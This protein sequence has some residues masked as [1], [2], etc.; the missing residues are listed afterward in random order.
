MAFKLHE[1]TERFR[2]AID[3]T[4]E[5]IWDWNVKSGEVKNDRYWR[6]FLGFED[7]EDL[8]FDS[9]KERVHPDS[10]TVFEN[11][12]REYLE[13]RRKY[14]EYEYRI[15]IKSGEWKW[16]WTRGICIEY[17]QDNRPVRFIGTHRDITESKLAEDTL[18]ELTRFQKGVLENDLVWINALWNKAAE[19]ISGYSSGEVL[20]HG[21]VWEWLYPDEKYRFDVYAQAKGFI[22]LGNR[23]EDGRERVILWNSQD[24]KDLN[25][26]VV[27]SV[28]LGVD[29]TKR[30][31]AEEEIKR[32]F[33]E[34]EV[35]IREI[36][37]RI[38]NN[39]TSVESLL[40]LQ[41]GSIENTEAKSIIY[42]AVN[43]V[44]SIR[45]IYDKLLLTDEYSKLSVTGYLKKLAQSVV[46]IFPENQ[47]VNVDLEIEDFT[48]D[49]KRLFLVGTIINELL[50]NSMKYAFSEMN[51]GRK[52]GEVYLSVEDNG[53]GLP[54]HFDIDNTDGFG[55]R[56]VKMLTQQL[57]GMFTI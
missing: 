17:D 53:S 5:G 16:I 21:K 19:G 10:I 31:N 38:K 54:E 9:W 6:R 8:T 48:L 7:A 44:G 12:L 41:A 25:G 55:L 45:R 27:G 34:K 35:L 24:I 43:R 51:T 4:G 36:H 26:K 18:A 29:V 20:G 11:A 30:K 3:G 15:Q 57:D 42:E 23:D 1:A 40:K 22:D 50:T 32:Q 56:L 28:A 14:F 39:I 2:L 37:H 47:R 52:N 46:D 49:V 13:G 33:R